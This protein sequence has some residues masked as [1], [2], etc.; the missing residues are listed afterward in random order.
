MPYRQTILI[1]ED[2]DD[3]AFFMERCLRTAGVKIPLKIVRDG[4]EAL[5]YLDDQ[6]HEIPRLAV[7]DIKMPLKGGFDV[8][9]KVRASPRLSRMPVI[10][11]SSSNQECD[12]NRAYDLG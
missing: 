7:L 12:V 1:A 10:I 11:F 3:T 4:V 8:L 2:D 9:K 6:D 5:D